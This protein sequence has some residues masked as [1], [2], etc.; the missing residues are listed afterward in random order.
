[1]TTPQTAEAV[2]CSYRQLDHA[3]RRRGDSKGSGHRRMWT[4]AEVVRLALAYQLAAAYPSSGSNATPFPWIA[5]AALAVEV[6][7][8]DR[9]Y[10]MVTGPDVSWVATWSDVR[11][12]VDD[13]RSAVVVAYDLDDLVGEVLDLTAVPR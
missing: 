6:E 4:P 13:H 2:G 9:G 1:M 8:P 3:A 10:A 7:P 5:A 12:T 11:R